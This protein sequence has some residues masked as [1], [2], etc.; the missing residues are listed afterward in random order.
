MTFVVSFYD[1]RSKSGGKMHL[2]KN[3]GGFETFLEV[4]LETMLRQWFMTIYYFS[5]MTV[6]D[7]KDIIRVVCELDSNP[8]KQMKNLFVCLFTIIFNEKTI[9]SLKSWYI[10]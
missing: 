4:R 8:N 7:I 3:S 1:F 2:K 10:F 9:K 6:T 5:W